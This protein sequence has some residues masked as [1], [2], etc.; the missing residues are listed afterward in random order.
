MLSQRSG[1]PP[2]PGP[3]AP[4]EIP[5][6]ERFSLEATAAVG[7][8]GVAVEWWVS[9]WV[10]GNDLSWRLRGGNRSGLNPGTQARVAEFTERQGAQ[11][12]PL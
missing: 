8:I 12:V 5:Q 4:Q 10:E 7:Y 11:H 3:G 2:A 1:L 9:H 6:A